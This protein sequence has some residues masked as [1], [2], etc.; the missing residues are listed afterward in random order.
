MMAQTTYSSVGTASNHPLQLRTNDTTALTIDTSQNAT[1][2]GT[3][4]AGSGGS[5][6]A[7]IITFSGDTNTGIF[8]TAADQLAFSAGGVSSLKLTTTQVEISDDLYVSVGAGISRFSCNHTTS[9]D[10]WAVSPISIRERGLVGNAQSANSYSPNINFHWANRVSRSL[11]M[12]ADGNFILGEWT[13]SGSPQTGSGLSNL[14]LGSININNVGVIDSSRNLTNIGSITSAGTHQITSVSTSF[15][16]FLV[17]YNSTYSNNNLAR[18]RQDGA[19]S[20]FNLYDSSGTAQVQLGTNTNNYMVNGNTGIGLNNPTTKLHVLGNTKIQSGHLYLDAQKFIFLGGLAF[21]RLNASGNYEIGDLDD[22]D[23]T[24]TIKAFANS[25]SITMG[26][27]TVAISGALS[28]TSGSFKIDHPLKPDTHHLVH[29]F[30]EGPQA[31]NLYRGKIDLKDGRAVIDLDEWFG[32]T[33]GTFLALNRDLQAFVSNEED[34]D[35]VRAKVM[36]SQ[37]VI[38]CQNARSKASVSWLVVGERQDN[39]IYESTLTDD[40]GKIIVEPVKQVV[41]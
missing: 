30:V 34:W 25:S 37:L 24:V 21:A 5:A 23:R 18:I 11:T 36:G 26:D 17:R 40:Y 38:E 8:R 19:A 12:K 6:S 15:N 27:G 4:A 22:D 32:M 39:E 3:I 10:D 41:E 31:D 1:F 20:I 7:P 33:P 9:Q 28:K 29:S 35:A 14:N 16:P 2:A 13:S